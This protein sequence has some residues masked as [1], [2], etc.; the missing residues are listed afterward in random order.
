MR[1]V[2][3]AF[4]PLYPGQDRL[5]LPTISHVPRPNLRHT[6]IS[7]VHPLVCS[8]TNFLLRSILHQGP[9]YTYTITV[10]HRTPLQDHSFSSILQ[11]TG[12][13]TTALRMR[14]LSQYFH[15]CNTLAPPLLPLSPIKVAWLD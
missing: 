3:I 1:T 10:Y 4:T 9:C 13:A 6:L 15:G 12:I 14:I 5:K 7:S 2:T 11:T 8:T